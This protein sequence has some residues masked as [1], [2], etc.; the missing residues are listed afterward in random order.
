VGWGRC[1]PLAT[2]A[3]DGATSNEQQKVQSCSGQRKSLLS[4]PTGGGGALANGQG[5]VSTEPSRGA[6]ERGVMR[7]AAVQFA[8]NR[9]RLSF[10]RQLI[11]GQ[12]T[13]CWNRPHVDAGPGTAGCGR[14]THFHALAL[15]ASAS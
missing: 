7:H 14:E 15:P 13:R 12:A 11:F 10:W 9:A 1:G 3:G 8:A 6:F 5:Q 4:P 2:Q